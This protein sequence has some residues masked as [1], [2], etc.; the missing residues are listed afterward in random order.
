MVDPM[1]EQTGQDSGKG[2]A[3]VNNITST[4]GNTT[5]AT[6]SATTSDSTTDLLQALLG[7]LVM[8]RG[9]PKIPTFSGRHAKSKDTPFS[10]WSYVVQKAIDERDDYGI[11]EKELKN[12]VFE[13]LAGEGRSRFIREDQAGKTFRQILSAFTVAYGDATPAIDRLQALHQMRQLKEESVVQFADRLEM[14]AYRIDQSP[15]AV[16]YDREATLK[17]V[18]LKGLFD[19]RLPDLMEHL[20]DNPAKK[21]DDFRARAITLET[22]RKAKVERKP[23]KAVQPSDDVL[24]QLLERLEKIEGTLKSRP[25]QPSQDIRRNDR[26]CFTCG[27]VGHFSRYCQM[28]KREG[29]KKNMGTAKSL[30]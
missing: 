12:I 28:T 27:E 17:A 5:D 11:S 9:K 1:G 30:N 22:E 15:E 18:F 24:K 13:S 7:R 2:E 26:K 19:S 8:K 21:Y 25:H 3:P 6:S 23:A 16:L 14:E 4:D 10:D 29:P 20:K